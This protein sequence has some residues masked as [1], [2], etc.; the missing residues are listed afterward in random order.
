MCC[1]RRGR[2]AFPDGG[3]RLRV[4]GAGELEQTLRARAETLTGVELTGQVPRDRGLEILA[5]ARA[6]VVPSRWYEVFP[7]IVAEAY[8]L[9]VP[10]IASRLGSLAEIVADGET[11]LHAEPGDAADLARALRRLA[12]DRD[13]AERLGAG[14]RARVRAQ[15]QPRRRPPTGCSRSTPGRRGSD[16]AAADEPRSPRAV[17]LDERRRPAAHRAAQPACRSRSRGDSA[18]FVWWSLATL[19]LFCAVYFHS[20][21][22]PGIRFAVKHSGLTNYG[23]S[24]WTQQKFG[25]FTPGDVAVF[26]FAY[27]GLVERFGTGRLRDLEPD[28]VA[29]RARRRP[30]C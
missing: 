8:A 12:D 21:T 2:Q 9:G 26:A 16:A 7:R 17:P 5:G 30:R 6:L 4:V 25:Q 23:P 15:P 27:A 24:W 10:V 28:G 13:L 14:A 18:R 22:D 3:Q 29:S 1:S 20:K 19:I 11:G